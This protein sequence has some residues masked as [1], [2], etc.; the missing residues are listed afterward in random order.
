MAAPV[1]SF[2]F[3]PNLLVV[4][5]TDT[6]TN[7][8]ASWLWDFGDGNTSFVQNPNHTYISEG[9]YVVT[10]IATNVDGS[11]SEI[12]QV[13]IHAVPILPIATFTFLP[14]DLIVQFTDTSLNGPIT[15]SW[16]FGDGSTL[17]TTQNPSHTYAA[18]G[19]YAVKLTIT[20]YDGSS[21]KIRNIG[22]GTNVFPIS[23]SDFIDGKLPLG[24]LVDPEMKDAY[25]AKWQ[26]YLQPL[27]IPEVS[28]AN[29]FNELAYPPLYIALIA[30]LVA[31]DLVRD[32]AA[33]GFAELV[34]G[35]SSNGTTTTTGSPGAI[36]KIVTG[37]SEV[38]FSDKGT[39]V[40][41]FFKTSASGQ[42][43]SQ[44]GPIGS[45]MQEACLLSRRLGLIIPNVCPPV[46]QPKR[47]WVKA[48]RN[49]SCI[50]PITQPGYGY[51]SVFNEL[52]IIF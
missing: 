19:I 48:G 2:T 30:S 8:P 29:T 35:S 1:A 32:T 15:W 7:T 28:V 46:P 52:Q 17:D 31:W 5:F 9:T 4:S 45:I 10:L 51:L 20:N 27:V 38:E 22:V 47:V 25:I 39:S 49:S 23:L 34:G 14:T 24:L 6:S 16:D 50:N 43:Y 26:L 41:N 42:T 13:T 21:Y 12:T 40:S 11:D 37:P 36:K 3:T 44:G 33:K 18:P